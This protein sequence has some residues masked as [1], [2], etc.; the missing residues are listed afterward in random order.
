MSIEIRRCIAIE[1][2]KCGLEAFEGVFLFCFFL[3]VSDELAVVSWRLWK[4]K[5]LAQVGLGRDSA[6]S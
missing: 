1:V 4:K 3:G 6:K 5:T 2:L